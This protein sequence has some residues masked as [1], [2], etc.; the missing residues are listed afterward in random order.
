MIDRSALL[1]DLQKLLT[2]LE[3]DLLQRSE[4]SDVPDV[5][6]ALRSEYDKAQRAQRTAQN[7][8]DWR[9]DAITQH[10]AAWVLACVFVRFLEDN[11]LIDPPKIAGPAER[12]QRARDEWELYLKAAQQPNERDYLLAVFDELAKLPGTRDVFGEHSPIREL[13]NWLSGDGARELLKFFQKIDANS[14]RLVHDFTDAEWDTRFLGDLYQ[15]LSEAARKKYALLQTPEFVE[16]FILERTLEPALDEFGLEPHA[17]AR[18]REEESDQTSSLRGSAPSRE[19]CFKMID[20]A[21]GSGHFLLGSFRRILDRWQRK[22]PGTKTEVL[23]QRTLDSVHGVDVNPFAIAIARFRLL[24]AAMRACGI[25]RLADAPAFRLNLV[26]GD[27]LLHAPLAAGG[28]KYTAGQQELDFALASD[29]EDSDEC[30][31][32]YRSENL[33]E[34]KR[35][36]R[37]GQYHAVVANPPYI[38]PKDRQLNERYRRRFL[39]CHG[40]YSLAVP[41]LERIFRL[42][43]AGGYTG[44]I[45]ANS[46]MKREFGKKLIESF[47]PTVDLTHVIDTAGAYIPGHGTPTVILFGRHRPPVASTLRTVMGIRSEPST[48]ADPARGLVWSAIIAQMDQPDSQSEFVSVGESIRELF[49]KHPWSIGGGGASELKELLDEAT[50]QILGEIADPGVAVVTLDD[51]AFQLDAKTACRSGI[52]LT[53]F[54][55]FVIGEAVRDWQLCDVQPAIFPHD[56]TSFEAVENNR[57]TRRLWPLKTGLVNRLWFRKTMPER[58]MSWFAYGHI[59]IQKFQTP[60]TIVFAFVATHNH[61]VLDRGGRVFNRSA[62]VIKLPREASEDDHLALLGV[63]NS[64]TACFWMQQT[65]HNK[66]RPGADV[67]AADERYEMRYEHDSTKLKSFPLPTGRPLLTSRLLDNLATR[68]RDFQPASIASRGAPT[69]AALATAQSEAQLARSQMIAAQEE[70]DWECYRLY[71]LIAA[72]TERPG[73]SRRSQADEEPAASALRLTTM[74]PP[75]L[76]LGQRAFEIVLARKMA[77][78][79]TQTTWFERHGSTPITE[80]PAEWPDDY[81]QLVERRIALIESD[82]NIRLIE[83]PEYKRRWNTEPWDS[84]LERALRE[85]LLD[86]LE[87][88]FDFDGRMQEG[89]TQR[90]EDTKAESS[91]PSLRAFVPLCEIALYSIAKLAD[92]A[93]QDAEFQQVGELYRNDPA[94][95]V[96][97]LVED[98][99]SAES[100]PLLPVLRYKDPGLRK[101]AEWEKTWE[102]QS[103]EDRIAAQLEAAKQAL[104]RERERVANEHLRAEKD[105]FAAQVNRLREEAVRVRDLYAKKV[106]FSDDTDGIVA[107]GLVIDRGFDRGF[108][109]EVQLEFKAFCK[110]YD[111]AFQAKVT[112]EIALGRACE[113]DA[114]FNSALKAISDVPDPP[115]ITVPPKYD[116]KDFSDS[117][118][119]RLR[120]KLDVPKERWVSFPHCEG[121]DGTLVIAWAGYDHLQMAQALSAYYVDIQERQGG[122]DDPRLIPLLGCLQELLPWVKQWHND[123][124]AEFDGLRMGDYFAGFIAEEARQLGKTIPEIQAWTPPVKVRKKAASKKKTLS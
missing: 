105:A 45:T 34:L 17:K 6:A 121:S 110:Q 8:E 19:T 10:A 48:P 39:S 15:D 53:F 51:D 93:R 43:V 13:P 38:T 49:H 46:F 68:A 55:G 86:R 61:F 77:A 12:L 111:Q 9:S 116:S 36:L 120:G 64:S 103:E 57:I 18:S 60:M 123:P 97:K 89:L 109:H 100:V 73:A 16:E 72:P 95:D 117:N 30:D 78:G 88:Y 124:N 14:G 66:G 112:F 70:L 3:D 26:C 118:Y 21:C 94:F 29:P 50:A 69:R 67:A 32:A 44:Q 65:F 113:K 102:L 40:K 33:P 1:S 115:K 81:R 31:H 20:P 52:A 104:E 59:S 35:L 5:G 98:L 90:H 22:E 25:A 41:F 119:W 2:K 85:W 101:R 80:L 4:S 82:P 91:S 96:Q 56:G 79:E 62:P 99:V 24:L 84:Q 47:F 122:R 42:A 92:V 107:A 37:G 71:G 75:P 27:S 108:E 63:L 83:Q 7:Y 54:R 106:E 58:G 87:S 28:K 114:A 23:V 11:R 74:Q 76:Q